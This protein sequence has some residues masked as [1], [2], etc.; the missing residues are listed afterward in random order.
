MTTA[1]SKPT[2]KKPYQPPAIV[3]EEVFETLALACA[4]DPGGLCEFNPPT[5]S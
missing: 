1:D 3:A 2:E 4:K 5:K